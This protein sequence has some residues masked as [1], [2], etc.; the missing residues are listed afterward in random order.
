MPLRGACCCP[1]HGGERVRDCGGPDDRRGVA[2]FFDA[3]GDSDRN[4]AGYS[5][6]GGSGLGP[7]WNGSPGGPG[8]KATLDQRSS[9]SGLRLGSVSVTWVPETSWKWPVAQLGVQSLYRIVAV[10]VALL[11]VQVVHSRSLRTWAA[12]LDAGQVRMMVAGW[13]LGVVQSASTLMPV[14][15]ERVGP[16]IGAD[17]VEP[18]DRGVVLGADAAAVRSVDGFGR[19]GLGPG[20]GDLCEA[21]TV[22][23]VATTTTV[24]AASSGALQRQETQRRPVTGDAGG[25]P[26]VR[27]T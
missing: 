17:A 26:S 5:Q 23:V 21:S 22:P 4:S 10:A 12:G 25:R 15:T 20:T 9:P 8:A 7:P 27:P 6:N 14:A 2:S 1:A 3:L 19:A 11:E 18:G 13:M 24:A 16:P